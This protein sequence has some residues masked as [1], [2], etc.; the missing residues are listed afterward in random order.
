MAKQKQ[1]K[2]TQDDFR[3]LL[4]L[5][6]HQSEQAKNTLN[7]YKHRSPSDRVVQTTQEKLQ[8]AKTREINLT[9]GIWPTCT[10][11]SQNIPLHELRIN[12]LAQKLF[13]ARTAFQKMD[14]NLIT[15]GGRA[16]PHGQVQAS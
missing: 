10:V 3:T 6:K 15:N 9:N 5:V 7:L 13:G 14:D 4:S 12:P 11:T 8:K 1:F 2:P 16:W